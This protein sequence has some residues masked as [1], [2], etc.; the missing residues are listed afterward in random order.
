MCQIAW[1]VKDWFE[2]L[3]R[4][5]KSMAYAIDLDYVDESKEILEEIF[6][7]HLGDGT[8]HEVQIIL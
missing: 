5:V 7:D 6:G 8:D 3:I 2:T 1:N 4:T